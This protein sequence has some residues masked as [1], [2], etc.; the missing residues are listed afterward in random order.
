MSGMVVDTSAA[1]ALLSGEPT[2]SALI[3]AFDT[4]GS[5]LMS[6]ASLV[7]LGIVLEARFG[8]VGFGIVERFLREAEVEIVPV[9]HEQAGVAVA[10][11][12]RFGKGR[13]VAALNLGDCFT[14]AL[15]EV[16]GL[17]ILCTGDGFTHT[18][19]SVVGSG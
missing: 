12:R 5:R 8:P 19:L 4:N 13:H 3:D 2:G 18:D 7:E 14:Y 11:W 17:P 9:D 10:A 1:V 16:S 15:A 6:A